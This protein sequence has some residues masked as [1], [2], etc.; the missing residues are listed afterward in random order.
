[1]EIIDVNIRLLET[2]IN[3]GWKLNPDLNKRDS[4]MKNMI[5]RAQGNI[6]ICPCKVYVE[7]MVDIAAVKCPCAEAAADIERDGMCHCQM[8][9]QPEG[10]QL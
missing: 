1:M 6:I 3:N 8:F 7:G 10:Q 4:L 9:F 5:K 2:A